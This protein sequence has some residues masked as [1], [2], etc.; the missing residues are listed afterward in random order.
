MDLS[1]FVGDRDPS[2]DRQHHQIPPTEKRKESNDV[3]RHGEEFD[4]RIESVGEMLGVNPRKKTRRDS[5]S[6][7]GEPDDLLP[8][9]IFF[10]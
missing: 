6:S 9:E 2:A 4:P 1:P 8:D 3:Q 7:E 5:M 10:D